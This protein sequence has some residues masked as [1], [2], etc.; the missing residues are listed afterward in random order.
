VEVEMSHGHRGRFVST[1][2]D[3]T[4]NAV[5]IQDDSDPIPA[6]HEQGGEWALEQRVRFAAKLVTVQSHVTTI[7]LEAPVDP[8]IIVLG[9]LEGSGS[10]AGSETRHETTPDG[11]RDDAQGKGGAGA[12]D[13]DRL[14][15]TPPE[16]PHAAPPFAGT[17][18]LRRRDLPSRPTSALT[19]ETPERS[20]RA[21]SLPTHQKLQE[22][23]NRAERFVERLL[24]GGDLPATTAPPER[25]PAAEEPEVRERRRG[26]IID[27]EQDDEGNAVV[28]ARLHDVTDP[29]DELEVE[30][31][32]TEFPESVRDL[33]EP[34]RVVDWVVT[35][36]EDDEGEPISVSKVRIVTK[37]E[38]G[39]DDAESPETR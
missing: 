19:S 9:H 30:F 32:A 36:Q 35:K 15:Y 7:E 2:P 16:P 28:W 12:E 3:A 31:A 1:I 23:L 17:V 11:L 10:R 20:S 37:V 24:V 6:Q 33:L 5:L 26:V 4:R 13:D 8:Q 14:T 22:I 39:P 21:F 18:L 29:Y 34:G 27:V 38:Y 25:P